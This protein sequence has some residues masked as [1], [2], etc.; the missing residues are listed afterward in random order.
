MRAVLYA[1]FNPLRLDR[2]TR[3][4]LGTPC[5]N[6]GTTAREIRRATG[7]KEATVNEPSSEG[8][9]Y[10]CKNCGRV[11][12]EQAGQ[13]R[14]ECPSCHSDTVEAVD[15]TPEPRPGLLQRFLRRGS[16]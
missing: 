8:L 6:P 11:F 16:P 15:K 14:Q 10:E 2:T 9:L 3:L 13:Q 7:H 12:Q 4:C 1:R 5:G